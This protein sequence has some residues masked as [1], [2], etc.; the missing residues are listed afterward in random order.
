MKDVLLEASVVMIG[1]GSSV[2]LPTE[3]A[4]RAAAVD[5]RPATV[6]KNGSCIFALSSWID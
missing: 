2:L 5:A 4:L 1:L 3:R 6:K